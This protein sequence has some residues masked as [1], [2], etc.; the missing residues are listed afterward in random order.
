[1]DS[2][3]F[4][5]LPEERR[6]NLDFRWVSANEMIPLDE[7]SLYY[8]I[9]RR[10]KAFNGAKAFTQWFF[11][12]ETQ[13][14]L[15]EAAKSK[16]LNETSYG[17]AGGFSAMRTV[18]EQ[19]FPAFYPDLLGR[20]PPESYLSPPNIL[21]HNW[22]SVKERVILPYLRERV[23]NSSGDEVRPLERRVNDWYRLNRE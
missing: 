23:R 12:A 16:R 7:W 8:G 9:H 19:V 4:F 1:M 10:T 15:L 6:T 20:M 18:T 3:R 14:L 22:T 13:R 2:S 21:P 17:I 11:T 5:T